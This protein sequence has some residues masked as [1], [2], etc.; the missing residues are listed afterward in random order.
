MS[1]LT[2]SGVL[3]RFLSWNNYRLTG[4]ISLLPV[5]CAAILFLTG[6]HPTQPFYLRDD[7]DLSYYLDTATD[8]E[9]P[10]VEMVSLE[11]V[12][13]AQAPLV[14]TDPKDVDMWDLTLEEAVHT[15][16]HNSKVIR[17]LGGSASS[18]APDGLLSFADGSST[19]YDPSIV[20]SDSFGVETALSEFDAQFSTKAFWQTTDRPQNVT[21][22][23]SVSAQDT[24]T[25]DF[26]L[27]KKS[28]TGTTF[29]ARNKYAY[30]ASNSTFQALRSAWTTELE[31]E[32]RQ[33]LMQGAGT[34]VNRAPVVLARI[35][36]DISLA[37]FEG[38]VRNLVR[39]VENAYWDLSCAYRNL[40][41][42]KAGRDSAM[43]TWRIVHEEWKGGVKPSQAEAQARGQYFLF[44]AQV[45][46]ALKGVYDSENRLRW[47]LGLA[48]TDGRLIRPI[49]EPTTAQIVFDWNE[50]HAEGLA[51]SVELRRQKWTIKQ[52]ETEMI[53]ARNKL[54]PRVDVTALY[55]WLGVG[56]Q[57]I[58]SERKGLNFPA[59]GSQAWDELTEGRYQEVRIGL[60]VTPPKF[61]LRAELAGVRNVE[62]KLARAYARLEDM[63]LNLSHSLTMD[64]RALDSHYQLAK[65]NF[66]RIV[67]A[68]KEV[69]SVQ[70]LYNNGKATLDLVLDALRRQ[71]DA[72][73]SYYRALCDY[74]KA[75]T[76]IHYRKGS[77]LEYN[78]IYLSEGPWPDKA[79]WDAEENSRRRSASRE[80]NYGWTRPGVISRGVVPQGVEDELLG[81]TIPGEIEMAPIPT[82]AID[83]PDDKGTPP[84]VLP[85]LPDPVV[86]ENL[87]TPRRIALAVP[88][89]DRSV[90]LKPQSLSV[91]EKEATKYSWGNM[92]LAEPGK[93]VKLLPNLDNHE[94]GLNESRPNQSSRQT[95]RGTTGWQGV[96]R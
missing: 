81:G 87:S 52:H 91:E 47:L 59:D 27:S 32:V 39:D 41:T 9:Y 65:T 61:G 21:L 80:I 29:I 60:E 28:A 20:S 92:Q 58:A 68:E 89:A 43:V 57:L 30:S 12:T 42:T 19:V 3:P 34:Q 94:K 96:H 46:T 64:I 63:E 49:D 79:Y 75:I 84:A 48:A 4:E 83:S 54:L 2:I 73:I 72:R 31:A 69:E 70:A 93:E 38:A 76:G 71:A 90:L 45:E 88:D 85:I 86:E 78:N 51:R 5:F 67:A 50:I 36:E 24:G 18:G 25:A 35:R 17:N 11:E 16:M 33:P 95:T 82:P 74:N 23:G 1:L 6:C 37:D 77:L 10:D 7:G 14:L 26:E 44:R 62:L 55:R 13:E 15:A 53:A 22:F 8:I 40:E 66:N 56:D